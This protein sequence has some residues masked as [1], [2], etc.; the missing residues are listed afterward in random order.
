MNSSSLFVRIAAVSIAV[1]VVAYFLAGML[2]PTYRSYMSLYFPQVNQG[3][4]TPFNILRP[5]G[6]ESDANIR[7]I[8]GLIVSP[9]VGSAP[10]T[11]MG[12]LNSNTCKRAVARE[13]DLPRQWGLSEHKAVKRLSSRTGTSVDKNGFLVVEVEAETP[14]L[15]VHILKSYL[16]HLDH[17]AEELTMNVS[18][19]NRQVIEDSVS[20]AQVRVDLERNILIAKMARNPGSDPRDINKVYL[21]VRQRYE[22]ARAGEAAAR[23]AIAQQEASLKEL[24][25]EGVDPDKR[26][27]VL[28]AS[29]QVLERLAT[30]L[31]DRR[32]ELADAMTRFTRDSK[33]FKAAEK[34]FKTIEEYSR[35]VLQSEETLSA[36]GLSPSLADAKVQLASTSKAVEEYA[37]NLSGYE[38]ELKRSPQLFAEIEEARLRF[39]GALRILTALQTDLHMAR[40]A[41]SRDPSRYEIVDLPLEDPDPVSPR[42]VMLAGLAF[43]VVFGIQAAPLVM[44]RVREEHD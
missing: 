18:K 11:A 36:R 4:S 41:E 43:L 30:E 3:Q 34:N 6:S 22:E 8:G 38:R 25:K 27:T 15:A 37:K 28:A 2:K 26:A 5:G 9:I 24:F 39:D 31:Q 35:K 1:A 20:E 16:K 32:V 17:R 21:E 42:R 40:I 29:N 44:Q 12:I 13:N 7:G 10:Q 33:E 14:E 23:S 19:R